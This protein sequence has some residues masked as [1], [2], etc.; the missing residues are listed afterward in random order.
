MKK[1]KKEIKPKII[2]M[3]IKENKLKVIPKKNVKDVEI[4]KNKY[5][6]KL[7]SIEIEY[8]KGTISLRKLEKN[9]DDKIE[10]NI[11]NIKEEAIKEQRDTESKI[12]SYKVF[13]TNNGKNW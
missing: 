3:K 10:Q 1:S 2:K 6:E 4:I 11:K 9:T 7:D 12:N 5:L 8:T 13:K